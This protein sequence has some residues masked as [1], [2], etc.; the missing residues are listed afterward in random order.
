MRRRAVGRLTGRPEAVG[1]FNTTYTDDALGLV[2]GIPCAI[3]YLE[4]HVEHYGPGGST[5]RWRSRRSATWASGCPSSAA[6]C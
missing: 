4:M 3:L 5:C 6:T 2:I 1:A